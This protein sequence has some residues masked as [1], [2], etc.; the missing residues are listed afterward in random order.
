MNGDADRQDIYQLLPGVGV[1]IDDEIDDPQRQD[2]IH[3][4]VAQL[5]GHGIPL[6]KYNA[7]PSGE[8]LR[9]LANIT[10]VLLD[11]ELL[12][13]PKTG[14][15]DAD[16]AVVSGAALEAENR[17]AVIGF[18]RSLRGCC[19]APVFLFTNLDTESI[20]RTLTEEKLP[21]HPDPGAH[22]FVHA[23]ADL[24]TSSSSGGESPLLRKLTD[25]IT[26]HPAL[27]V[28]GQWKRRLDAAQTHLF[29]DLFAASPGW[30][31]ALWNASKEDGDNPD[32]ALC[33]I[34]M[35]SMKAEM[36]PLGLDEKVIVGPDLP[37][38]TQAELRAILERTTIVPADKLPDGQYGCG[39]LFRGTSDGVT[40][41]RLNIRCDCDCIAHSGSIDDV[42]LY[43]LKAKEVPEKELH[44][45]DQIF[46]AQN[47]FQRPMHRAY[48][49]PVDGGKCLAVQFTTLITKTI[50][51]ISDSGWERVG[52]ITSPHLTDI[53]HRFSN[54]LHREGFPKIPILAV[55]EQDKTAPAPAKE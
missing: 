54:F 24:K 2:A 31:K 48:I 53:R 38:A 29:W 51:S 18:L 13:K 34:L 23:K 41:Y 16:L 55:R 45:D 5:E 6:V 43:L 36:E 46:S 14:S 21:Q 9:A 49:F 10:F 12:G 32:F 27:Y 1:V 20:K 35:R 7:L 42:E 26:S 22:I 15:D 4:L 33:E 50:K 44:Q 11:W 28:I 25:W 40:F 19:F 47:G 39:D 17:K 3:N 8:T 30:P 37:E 52:R